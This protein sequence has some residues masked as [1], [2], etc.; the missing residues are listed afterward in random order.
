MDMQSRLEGLRSAKFVGAQALA[1]AAAEFLRSSGIEQERGTVSDFPDERTIRFY[2]S[3][4]LIEAA[5]ERR[6]SASV[7]SY[8][9]LLQLLVIKKLQAEDFSIRKIREI[10]SGRNE[11][12]L[13]ALLTEDRNSGPLHGDPMLYLRSLL[14]RSELTELHDSFVS[15]QLLLQSA[16]LIEKVESEWR[17]VELM[18][19]LELHIRDD[20]SINDAKRELKRISSKVLNVLADHGMKPRKTE[21]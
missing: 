13:E 1:D 12:D 18:D 4:G 9:N 7:F 17:R 8:S 21:E 5:E 16:P 10:V 3:E 2:L 11:A 15:P 19:G 14:P 20:F 6:G